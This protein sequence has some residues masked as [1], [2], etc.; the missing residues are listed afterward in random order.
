MDLTSYPT[1]TLS[2]FKQPGLG[3]SV[4]WHQDGVTHWDSVDWDEGYPWF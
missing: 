3:G 2:S 1:M 4:A